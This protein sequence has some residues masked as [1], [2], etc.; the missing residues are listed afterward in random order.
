MLKLDSITVAYGDTLALDGIDLSISAGEKI[1]LIGPSGA[2]KTTLLSKLHKAALNE[3][4]IE[5]GFIHQ[6]FALIEQLSVFHNVYMG[7]LDNFS[8]L[9]NL[10]NFLLPSKDMKNKIIPIL[11][12]LGLQEKLHVKAGELSGGQKQRLAIARCLFKKSPLILADEPVS[13]VDPRQAESVL[14]ILFGAAPTVVVSLHTTEMA[15]RLCSRLLALREG[16]LVFDGPPQDLSDSQLSELFN[17]H[18]T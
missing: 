3:E 1:G 7:Q 11:E 6:D 9:K 4:N 10:R 12:Q 15:L 14:N 8:V 17:L 18:S 13:S 2:G 5:P 16:R